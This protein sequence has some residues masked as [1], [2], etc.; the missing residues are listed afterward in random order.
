MPMTFQVKLWI[1][2]LLAALAWVATIGVGV[3]LTTVF[4]TVGL[5]AF[6]GTALVAFVLVQID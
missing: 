4:D 5:Y 2:L 3:A 1:I 6:L